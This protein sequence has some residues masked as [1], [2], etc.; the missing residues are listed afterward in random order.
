VIIARDEAENLPTCLASL[1]W[2]SEIVVVVDP[3]SRDQTETIARRQANVVLVRPFDHFAN[4]RN[5]GI[6]RACGEWIFSI[7]AD[8]QVSP[9][10][11]EEILAV[12]SRP[13]P[14]HAGYRV[15]IQSMILGRRFGYS[16]TQHDRPIRLFRRQAGRWQGRVHEVVQ[17]EGTPGDLLQP[18]LH[19]TLPTMRSFLRK[20]DV[21][22]SLEAEQ[23]LREGRPIRPWD[24][25]LRPAW[26][27]AK[28]YLAKQGFRDGMEG[29]MFCALSGM[30]VAVRHW[31]H[32]ELTRRPA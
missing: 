2:A 4:Q 18:I 30:S 15:P 12:T 10:L 25:T 31:K 17:L 6:E 11:A 21:Y 3:A 20:L 29:F 7:D 27:F 28:L 19:Q 9:A 26:T 32:R 22:T 1:G 5:A 23:F 14:E 8:E 13:Q 24:V 16:G